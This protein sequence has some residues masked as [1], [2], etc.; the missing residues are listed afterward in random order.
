MK[1]KVRIKKDPLPKAEMG[2][3]TRGKLTNNAFQFPINSK[4]GMQPGLDVK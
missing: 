1:Y 3:S 2:A 4:E